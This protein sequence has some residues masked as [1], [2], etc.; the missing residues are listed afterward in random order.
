MISDSAATRWRRHA[1]AAG[2]LCSVWLLGCASGAERRPNFVV[3]LVDTL[4]GDHLGF[5]GGAAL[6]PHVDALRERSVWFQNAYANAPWTLPSL[7]SLFTSRIP[8]RHRV[9]V[10]GRPLPDAQ[11]SLAEVL[12]EAGYATGAFNANILFDAKAGFGQGF[13]RYQ[14]VWH[15]DALQAGASGTFPNAPASLV[16]Q[17]AVAWIRSQ[18]EARPD[19]PL[20]VY[21]QYMEPHTP[22]RCPSRAEPGCP[23]RAQVLNDRLHAEQWD[24][25]PE[26]RAQIERLYAAEV[27]AVDKGLGELFA[28]L[29]SVGLRD[30]TWLVVTS[31][32]GEQLG[33]DGVYLHGKSLDREEIRIPLLIHGPGIAPGSV[34]TPTS[35]VDLAPTILDAAGIPAPPDFEGRSLLPALRG[36]ALEDLPV[37]AEIFQ[38][39]ESP[40]RHRL[41]V[42]T[43]VDKLVL[44]P[45]GG[46]VR[47][48]LVSDP[49][50]RE[51]RP[52]VR[53]ELARALGEFEQY[54]DFGE[55]PGA[56]KLDDETRGRLRALGYDRH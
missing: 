50:E 37:I 18:R 24:F 10:W 40:P 23:D 54:I 34:D 17:Q 45:A 25:E 28:A 12:R 30:A 1:A 48:D 41:A 52:A 3:V 5:A 16:T 55:A 2:L 33:K 46:V 4:R 43:R 38:T 7:A 9:V 51:P 15:P 13:D 19:A 56:P 31:D 32:H 35:L 27:D 29:D 39:T 22:Y 47:Y 49:R 14:V 6:T 44:D 53:S 42:M 26:D 36:D 20:F 8:S 11:L 21:L